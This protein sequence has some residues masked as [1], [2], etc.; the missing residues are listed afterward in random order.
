MTLEE[1]FIGVKLEVS[2][3]R[4]LCSPIYVHIPSKK[5][6]KLEPTSERG[7]FVGYSETSKAYKIYI[8]TQRKIIVRRDV[9]FEG[10]RTFRKSRGDPSPVEDREREAPKAE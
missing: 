9:K 8:P 1:V 6:T 10:D 3:L 4:I 7:I 5:K 2:H